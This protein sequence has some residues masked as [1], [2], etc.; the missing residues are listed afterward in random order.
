MDLIDD[1]KRVF[2]IRQIVSRKPA[3]RRFYAE[4]Y[5][6]YKLCLATCPGSGM[7]VE[8]GSG[9][10]FAREYIPDLVTTDILPYDGVDHVV[11]A[12]SMPFGECSLRFICMLNVFHHIP[13]VGAFLREAVRCLAP[14]GKVLII[15]QHPGWIGSFVYRHLHHEPFFPDAVDWRFATTGPLSGANGALAWIV[16]TRDRARFERYTPELGLARY[17]PI[18]PL[19][20]WLTGGLKRWSLLPGWAWN[21][22]TAVDRLLLTLSPEFGSFVEIEL[23]RRP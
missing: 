19:R 8:L 15:D 20:Y 16:F 9:A 18:M 4:I 17:A 11:D 22:A 13:D 10:G 23:V 7:A 6:K 21:A 14:G 1:P 5:E 2:E 3:L 12:T